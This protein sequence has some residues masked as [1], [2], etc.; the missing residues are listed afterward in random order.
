M[1]GNGTLLISFFFEVRFTL[2]AKP[3]KNIMGE[4]NY[5]PTS[6]IKIEANS[7]TNINNFS[8]I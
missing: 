6:L 2:M 5:R 4:E 1:N 3:D 7:L 8:S